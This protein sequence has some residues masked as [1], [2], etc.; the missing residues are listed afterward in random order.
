MNGSRTVA[1]RRWIK[2]AA[3]QGGLEA[4]ALAT[5]SGLGR[6]ARG[7]GSIFTLHHVRPPSSKAFDPTA[8]L[9][10][11]PQFLEEAILALKASGHRALRLD[12][13]PAHLENPQDTRPVMVFTLDDGYRDNAEH[14]RPVFERHN[15]PFT[16][17][18]TGGFVDRTHSIWWKTAEALL[19]KVETFELDFGEGLTKWPSKTLHEKYAAFDRLHKALTCIRQDTIVARLDDYAL[20]NGISPLDIVA[21]ET[22]DESALR[23]LTLCPLANLGAHTISHSNLAHMDEDLLLR[24]LAESAERVC[25]ITG[26]KPKSFAYPYGDATAAGR[27]EFAAAGRAGFDLAVTTRPGVLRRS[28]SA[29]LHALERISLNGYYQRARY[30]KALASGLPFAARNLVRRADPYKLTQRSADYG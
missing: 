22:M 21:E 18:V 3:I 12:D 5:G 7:L 1:T 19:A 2:R 27:R 8:H 4:M 9:A 24:E 23:A 28:S 26:E 29:A 13:L 16:V 30:V 25:A 11:T 10:I 14:A 17:F 20:R 6:S 15:I